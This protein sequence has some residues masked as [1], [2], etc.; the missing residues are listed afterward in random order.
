MWNNQKQ[1]KILFSLLSNLQTYYHF[2]LDFQKVDQHTHDK[3]KTVLL[4][5]HIYDIILILFIKMGP[6]SNLIEA[7]N[8]PVWLQVVCILC[9][10]SVN[11]A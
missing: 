2:K 10:K 6:S 7:C 1:Q 3:D 9:E 8:W 4:P 5:S 11:S